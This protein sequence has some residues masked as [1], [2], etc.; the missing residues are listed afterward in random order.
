MVSEMDLAT[1]ILFKSISSEQG[2][3]KYALAKHWHH[4]QHTKVRLY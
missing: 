4:I 3:E 2:S 1:E